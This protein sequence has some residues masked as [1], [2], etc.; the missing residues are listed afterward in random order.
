M[1]QQPQQ[2]QSSV[3]SSALNIIKCAP[4]VYTSNSAQVAGSNGS[5]TGSMILA[6]P[7]IGNTV[8]SASGGP[9]V[10]TTVPTALLPQQQQIQLLKTS[11]TSTNNVILQPVSRASAQV[12]QQVQQSRLNQ[13]MI[14][15]HQQQISTP[16]RT[17]PTTSIATPIQS[18]GKQ[19]Q[20]LS[21]Q[22]GTW[23]PVN[24]NSA[25]STAAAI[26][27]SVALTPKTGSSSK[28]ANFISQQQNIQAQ[29]QPQ[30]LYQHQIQQQYVQQPSK[31]TKIS[32]IRLVPSTLSSSSS[33]SSPSE[34]IHQ[35]HVDC[36]VSGLEPPLKVLRTNDRSSSEHALASP[37]IAHPVKASGS[38][39]EL[40]KPRQIVQHPSSTASTNSS[41]ESF[42]VGVAASASTTSSNDGACPTSSSI[43]TIPST[44][45]SLA[46]FL[47]EMAPIADSVPTS[48]IS[49]AGISNILL[50][51]P[52]DALKT[53]VVST[54]DNAFHQDVGVTDG[55]V[56][57]QGS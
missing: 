46:T 14:Q 29:N 40:S 10:Q 25:S 39:V 54:A 17:I 50:T 33:S 1:Q 3:V 47:E 15:Q 55:D 36:N 13:R 31:Q 49:T 2:Q 34:V 43:T 28:S 22:T 24:I 35:K 44:S 23:S 5:A 48:L 11:T 45:E 56:F 6:A 41:V 38:S 16:I 37:L 8:A 26:P 52:A 32:S 57:S 20:V 21:P 27:L 9:Q 51:S 12:Q 53:S 18:Y 30:L 4:V 7:T 42:L 19:I